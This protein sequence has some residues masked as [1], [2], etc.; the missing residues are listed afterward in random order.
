MHT[1]K[2]V[3]MA[4][5]L[6]LANVAQAAPVVHFY[7]WSDYIGE[8]TLADF[9]VETGIGVVYDLYSSAEE[10]QAKLLAVPGRL[11]QFPGIVL[12]TVVE[13]HRPHDL[14]LFSRP[15]EGRDRVH[16]AAEENESLHERGTIQAFGISR[17]PSKFG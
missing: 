3:T 8:T 12:G 15:V 10:A 9:E 16:A 2:I 17:V 14:M 4:L 6:G 13:T 1:T 7:N 5:A 11:F